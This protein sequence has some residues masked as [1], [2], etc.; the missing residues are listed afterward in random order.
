MSKERKK[1]KVKQTRTEK[2]RII[3][4]TSQSNEGFS[5]NEKIQSGGLRRMRCEGRKERNQTEGAGSREA[6]GER[7]MIEDGAL[8]QSTLREASN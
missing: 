1:K 6:G 2:N 7:R 3:S 5:Q 4:E 8:N